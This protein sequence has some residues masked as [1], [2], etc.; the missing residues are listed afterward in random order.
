M[1]VSKI[2]R[3]VSAYAD[4]LELAGAPEL[5]AQLRTL[6]A[7]L[8]EFGNVTVADLAAQIAK[9]SGCA[10]SLVSKSEDEARFNQLTA[11]LSALR[12]ILAVSGATKMANQIQLLA[13][14]ATSDSVYLSDMLNALRRALSAPA[15]N[16]RAADYIE[17]LKAE[18]GTE[19]FEHTLQE[20]DASPLKREQVVEIACGVY[21]GIPKRTSRK[22]AIEFI[23]K[24]HDARVSARRGVDALGGRSAA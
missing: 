24:P 6:G 19:A 4:G 22:A 8:R 13:Q 23:R 7:F 20:I 18:I 3:P 10:T 11:H 9:L 14:V 17:R 2:E 21:G 1:K 5:A 16:A 15:G 12:S